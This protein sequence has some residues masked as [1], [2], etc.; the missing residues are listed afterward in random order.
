MRIQL[1]YANAFLVKALIA[2][3]AVA[4]VGDNGMDLIEL[5]LHGGEPVT[6]HLIERDIDVGLIETLLN[7]DAQRKRASLF[8]LWSD[9]LLPDDGSWYRPYDWMMAL[10]ALYGDKIYGFDVYGTNV[11]MFPVYF[12]QQI[13][14]PE[15]FI[16]YGDTI[17]MTRI[18]V[19]T[20][21][22]QSHVKGTWRVVDFEEGRRATAA[23]A[24]TGQRDERSKEKEDETIRFNRMRADRNP[25]WVYYNLLGLD[26]NDN[27]DTVRRAYRE[28]ARKYHPDRN[29]SLEATRRMQQ[30][31]LAYEQIM[32]WLGDE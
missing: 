29:P 7:E 23:N 11:T 25:L 32:K 3:G 5:E 18:G 10:L 27:A 12:E 4:D 31:N 8:I 28:L 21:H 2:A 15:Y 9:M 19:E 1:S 17:D 22:A 16:R 14:R 26:V 24:N 13:G 6:A 30:I 20:V